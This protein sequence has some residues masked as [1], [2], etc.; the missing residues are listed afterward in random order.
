MLSTLTPLFRPGRIAVIGASANP[1]KMGFQIFRNI[2]DAGFPGEVVPVNPKGEVILGLPSVRSASDIPEG[3]D[4]AV[5][6]IPAKLVPAT[7]LQL[8][9]RKVRSAIVITGGFA[10]S[11]EEGA[12][13]QQELVR[14]ARRCGIRVI[15]PNCQ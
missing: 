13:L 11:G 7:M 2:L 8:G 12:A 9:E 14:N 6:I 5:V 1:E 15:G 3:T 4:L 10:E